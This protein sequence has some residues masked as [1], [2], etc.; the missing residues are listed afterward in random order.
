MVSVRLE[1]SVGSLHRRENKGQAFVRWIKRILK[2]C[3]ALIIV[4]VI[5]ALTASFWLPY[6]SRILEPW[7][8]GKLLGVISEFVVPE[9][10]ID[11]IVYSWPLKLEVYG[12][13]M[14]A[15]TPNGEGQIDILQVDHAEITLDEIPSSG[16]LIFRNFV[17]DSP[18]ITLRVGKDGNLAGWDNFL[19][20]QATQTREPDAERTTQDIKI[21]DIF[22]IDH[23]DIRDF[24]FVYKVE[25]VDDEMVLDKLNFYLTNE[26]QQSDDQKYTEGWY[27]INTTLDREE[28]FNIQID[29]GFDINTLETKANKLNIDLAI[30]PTSTQHLPPQIQSLIREFDIS[31]KMDIVASGQCNLG[32]FRNSQANLTCALNASHFAIRD[33]LFEIDSAKADFMFKDDILSTDNLSIAMLDGIINVSGNIGPTDVAGL[34]SEKPTPETTTSFIQRTKELAQDFIPSAAIQKVNDAANA[35]DL[36]LALTFTD[37]DLH[38][39]RRAHSDVRDLEGTVNGTLSVD[40]N[41]GNYLGTLVGKGDLKITKGVLEMHPILNALA[42]VMNVALLG[43]GD[44]DRADAEFTIEDKTVNISRFT[45]LASPIGVRGRGWVRFDQTLNLRCNAGPLEAL[46][47]STGFI[48][49]IFGAFTDRL[50]DYVIRGT[51]DNPTVRIAPLGIGFW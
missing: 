8:R 51:I 40:G 49:S 26:R 18:S 21:S 25:G 48:G 42:G 31:S 37:V 19:T 7:I 4:G 6:A 16:P 28:L 43:L 1:H 17:L 3:T 36:M 34:R 20:D 32:D 27:A 29:G 33:R 30:N 5:A 2:A 45:V 41:L 22:D 15:D 10:R 23:I 35:M 12:V 13:T 24:S 39:I 11:R 38:E 9:V 46:Q 44:D 50:L 47:E 14:T